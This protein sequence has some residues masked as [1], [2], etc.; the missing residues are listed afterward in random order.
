MKKILTLVSLIA[1]LLLA[2]CGGAA[3]PAQPTAVPAAAEPTGAPV[4]E[5]TAVPTAE[6]APEAA[7][8][9]PVTIKHG[10]GETTV[11]AQP[12]RIVVLEWSLLEDLLALGIQPV[13]AADIA[14]YHSWVKIPVELDPSV[15]DVGSRREPSL[16]KIAELKPD[17]I[18]AADFRSQNNYEQLSQIAPTI[19]FLSYPQDE[20]ISQY[21]LMITTFNEIAAVTGRVSEAEAVLAQLDESFANLDSSLEAAGLKG[22]QF[23]LAQ[24]FTSGDAAEIR[25]FTETSLASE[26]LE[27]IGLT[28]GWHD[29]FQ[30][31]G[32]STI[33][34][35]GLSELPE[36]IHFFYVVQDD[37]NIF[38]SDAGQT[39]WDSLGFVK[40][41][42]AYPLGADTWLF[43]GPLSAQIIAEIAANTLVPNIASQASS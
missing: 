19:A 16:E 23:V 24:G 10:L 38:A 40:A 34:L 30:L 14:G 31:Y 4:V 8:G 32:Y 15:V 42:H 21:E 36:D 12:S 39:V 33:S 7:S 41:G 9:F 28:P 27:K 22:A 17:L 11:E 26:V 37:D 3:S 13:G 6:P 18:L 43:G 20:S 29:S 35:E 5:A 2:A 25:L 1:A